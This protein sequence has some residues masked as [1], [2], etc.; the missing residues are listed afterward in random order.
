MVSMFIREFY[1]RPDGVATF[2]R[3]GR[4]QRVNEVV[5]TW[6][7]PADRLQIAKLLR[8]SPPRLTTTARNKKPLSGMAAWQGFLS[9]QFGSCRPS[10]GRLNEP[11]TSHLFKDF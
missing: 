11:A 9:S 1:L 8:P 5:R 4:I 2:G 6:Q 3:R 10:I 7:R